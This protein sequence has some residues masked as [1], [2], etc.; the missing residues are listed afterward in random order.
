MAVE[1]ESLFGKIAITHKFMTPKQVNECLDIQ[2]RMNTY[3]LGTKKI[4]EIAVE[5]RFLTEQQLQLILNI[6]R[7]VLDDVRKKEEAARPK[8]A[9]AAARPRARVRTPAPPVLR[10]PP[11]RV[12]SAPAAR[13]RIDEYTAQIKMSRVTT[14]V[15]LGVAAIV[16][17]II[18]ASLKGRGSGDDSPPIGP[19]RPVFRDPNDDM[20]AEQERVK[21]RRAKEAEQLY[22]ELKDWAAKNSGKKEEIIKRCNRLV[23]DYAETEA[24][25]K[26]SLLADF[27]AEL[28]DVPAGD[29]GNRQAA[30]QAS[31]IY[32]QLSMRAL[33]LRAKEQWAKAIEVYEQFPD[34]FK[35]TAFYPK[36]QNEVKKLRQQIARKYEADLRTINR[37]VAAGRYGEARQYLAKIENYASHDLVIAVQKELDSYIADVEKTPAPTPAAKSEDVILADKLRVAESMFWRNMYLPAL[38]TY[39]E[40]GESPQFVASHPEV[41]GRIKDLERIISVLDAAAKDL[42]R[43]KGRKRTIYLDKGGSVYAEIIDI[44]EHEITAYEKGRGNFEIALAE[45]TTNSLLLYAKKHLPSKPAETDLALGTFYLSR[46]LVKKAEECVYKAAKKDAPNDEVARL[47]DRLEEKPPPVIDEVAADDVPE[48]GDD[49]A[50]STKL[51]AMADDMF[52]KGKYAEALALYKELLRKFPASGPVVDNRSQIQGNIAAC[53]EKLSSPLAR[54]FSGKVISRDDLGKGVAEI[55]YSFESE[56]QLADWKEYNWYSIFDMHDSNWHIADGELSGNGSRGFLWKGEIDGDV[57][58]EFDAYAT[59]AERQNIQATICDNGEG[60]NYLFAVGLTELGS[61]K[62][63]IRR[64][65]KFSFGKEIAKRASEAK[66]FKT[67]HVKIVKQG[68]SLSLYVDDELVLK[69]K[70]NLYKKGHVGLFA[71]GSTVRFDNVTITGR[72]DKEWLKKNA[73]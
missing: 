4:G 52:K 70:H 53:E 6:Q 42:I 62:D 43:S 23:I 55:S 49:D 67:Y 61:A 38:K 50:G 32:M 21:E 15:G 65:E 37:L 1:S 34:N 14:I 41:R 2:A 35:D 40:L 36:V 39:R 22:Q 45:L 5:R 7:A 17:V 56:K 47:L 24:A 44:V 57:K 46:G 48:S 25:S 26:A 8:P 69:A 72:L 63:I 29:T 19:R 3:G 66:S 60:W 64:N 16:V 73:K 27:Y 11:H 9:P 58:V 28:P 31:Q 20:A 12:T 18:L 59:S 30:T 13:S 51:L 68:S 54:I 33:K 71:I 10:P